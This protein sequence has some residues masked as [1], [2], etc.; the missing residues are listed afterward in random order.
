M[1]LATLSVGQVRSL[2]NALSMDPGQ[3]GATARSV[4][5]PLRASLLP[6]MPALAQVT[7]PSAPVQ[8]S[9]PDLTVATTELAFMA[10]QNVAILVALGVAV[11][12]E[13]A[14][15][16][17]GE[18]WLYENIYLRVTQALRRLAGETV[19]DTDYTLLS[20]VA[21]NAM[22]AT[23]QSRP[24]LTPADV[25]KAG[26]LTSTSMWAVLQVEKAG[27]AWAAIIW[28][29]EVAGQTPTY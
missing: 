20:D 25:F 22:E 29:P 24:D 17:Q 7:D 19:S 3:W 4:L 15:A 1:K 11:T 2:F 6:Q 13:Q 14:A 23:L 27:G 10:S 12:P 5:L 9:F 8:V 18:R 26:R 16:D 21:W 28:H